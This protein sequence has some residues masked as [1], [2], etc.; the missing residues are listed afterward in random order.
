M[1]SEERAFRG[2]GTR[3]FFSKWRLNGNNLAKYR[4]PTLKQWT[5]AIVV[6]KWPPGRFFWAVF[7]CIEQLHWGWRVVFA[8]FFAISIFDPNWLFCKGYSFWMVAN[9]V[10]FQNSLIFRI[11]I[12]FP[13]RFF[14]RKA[15][16][17]LKS[18]FWHFFWNLV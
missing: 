16:L 12:V 18:R 10:N 13:S 17:G 15:A 6:S 4:K 14:H 8:T 5:K 9:F 11:L 7:F 1:V 2:L 3:I